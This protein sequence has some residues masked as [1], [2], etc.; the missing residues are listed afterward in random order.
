VNNGVIVLKFFLNVSKAE[1]KK[2]FLARINEPEKNW[3]FSANDAKERA[4]WNDYMNAYEDVFNHTST[5]WAP[6]HIIP[7][8]HKWFTR[9]VVA[10]VIA[11][12]LASLD[13]KYP[14][15]MEEHKQQLITAKEM[16]K[17]EPESGI[18]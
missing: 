13:L 3:K 18:K 2:R 16:L 7:A 5:D 4:F 11:N 14:V 9:L 10:D 12:K 1:Q 15:L 8:D 6:W 17:H